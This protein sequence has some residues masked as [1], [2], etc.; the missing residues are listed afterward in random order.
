MKQIRFGIVGCGVIS[1]WHAR[2]IGEIEGAVLTGVTDIR[3]ESAHAFG[4]KYGAKAFA[5]LEELLTSDIDAVCIC[6]PSG[7]HASQ[8]IQAANSGKHIVLEKPIGITAEQLDGLEEAVERNGVKLC[9]VSQYLFSQAMEQ[10]KQA[11]ESGRLGKLILGDI[12]MKFLRTREYYQSSSWR[13]T[14]AMDGGGALMNQGIHGV[15]MLLYLMGPVKRVTAH[16]RTLYHQIEVEDTAVALLEF[17][18]GALGHIVGTTSVYPGYP[19]V[20]QVTGENGTIT[21]TEDQIT[22][23]RL[24]DE[25]EE[26]LSAGKVTDT[27]SVP[28]NFGIE[29][30]KKLIEDFV[31]AVWEDCQ[32]K[33]DLKK[34]REAVD[35]ILAIYESSRTGKTITL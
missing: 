23:W 10:A 26:R 14:W 31:H 22:G 2:A 33:I 30:H 11:V 16:V 3:Q 28:T 29:G 8:A 15:G 7:L 32:P 13:G 5:T 9:A 20:L 27:S 21:I 24:R 17:E 6:T 18:N 1:D 25:P 19:R 35:L 34:G 4:Q 12:T